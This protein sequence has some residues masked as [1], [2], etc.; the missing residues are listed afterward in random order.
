MNKR[1]TLGEEIA[2]SISHGVG[3]LLSAVGL[4]I[5][6]TLSAIYGTTLTIVSSA[7]Y[8]F[9][10]FFMYLSSTLY[11]AFTG[12][13]LKM[14]FKTIDHCAI[15]LLIAGTYTPFT[16][17]TLRGSVGYTLFAFIW[18]F[19]IFGV[20]INIIDIKKYHK[21]SLFCHVA[22]G[23][24]VVLTIKPLLENLATNGVILLVLGGIAY[25]GGISF[26]LAKKTPY[27]HMIWHFCVLL[28]S[29]FHFLSIVLYVIAI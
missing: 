5:L 7:I 3:A 4:G 24:S 15:F 16:L 12:E 19:A 8:G 29:I 1:Y 9:T 20:I 13:K 2:N 25:T 27:M 22:M 6:I 21:L 23:W 26:Y 17:I 11:H 14:L 18:L 28:G 10:L